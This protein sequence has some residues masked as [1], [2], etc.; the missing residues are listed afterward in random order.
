MNDKLGKTISFPSRLDPETGDLAITK[1]DKE[2]IKQQINDIIET[3]QGER[4]MMPN[5]SLPASVLAA[6][7]SDFM[8]K[9]IPRFM[10]NWRN[11]L[12]TSKI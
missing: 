7:D 6:T 9:L 12:R 11:M 10:D 3:Q 5:Y 1:N 4:V 2:V 8:A